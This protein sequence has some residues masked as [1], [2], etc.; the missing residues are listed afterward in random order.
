MEYTEVLKILS[1]VLS[2]IE[3]I[4]S[5]IFSIYKCKSKGYLC[6][7]R[8][9]SIRDPRDILL[10]KKLQ[11]KVVSESRFPSGLK[12][13]SAPKG[14]TWRVIDNTIVLGNEIDLPIEGEI[15]KHLLEQVQKEIIIESN[16]DEIKA[17]DNIKITNEVKLEIPN[18]KH[19]DEI[20]AADNIKITNEIMLQIANDKENLLIENTKEY[21][22]SI[23][24]NHD[25]EKQIKINDAKTKSDHYKINQ[26][27]PEKKKNIYK[28]VVI[29]KSYAGKTCLINR[30]IKDTFSS[31]FLSTI[32]VDYFAKRVYIGERKEAID[33]NICDV[34]GH[35]RYRI[36]T[37]L[38]YKHAD[39]IILAFDVCSNNPLRSV[40][41]FLDDVNSNTQNKKIVLVGLK[42]DMENERNIT[43]QEA[44]EFADINN[45]FYIEA[46]AKTNQNV[47]MVFEFIINSI[48]EENKLFAKYESISLEQ[49]KRTISDKITCC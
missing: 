12:V 13:P 3:G 27:N 10:A 22:K 8:S 33:L 14:K 5:L 47:E 34:T 42:I 37:N 6:F 36:L 21:L 9:I 2:V 45:I 4:F 44:K 15:K 11:G 32:P 25:V 49:K 20:K 40:K 23:K 29:G 46:S 41:F 18:N 30:Y 7:K 31:H 39:A 16:Q 28:I 26:V 17:A 24:P 48:I 35:K 1:I 38:Y 43:Y 19:D